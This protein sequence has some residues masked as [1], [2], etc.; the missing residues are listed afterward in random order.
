MR[1]SQVGNERSCV[2]CFS[3]R[4][5]VAGHSVSPPALY[6]TCENCGYSSIVPSSSPL[7]APPPGTVEAVRVERLVRSIITDFNLPVELV[8]IA[9]ESEGWRLTLRTRLRRPVRVHID[10]TE[11]SAIR[12]A[13]TRALA[14]A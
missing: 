12:M 1:T 11:P 13:M 4:T 8:A 14:N 7:P 6:V 10:S 5:R 9:D 2:K 3:H